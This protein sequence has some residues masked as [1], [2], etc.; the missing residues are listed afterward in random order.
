MIGLGYRNI[1]P[2]M[3]GFNA[4]WKAGR[5]SAQAEIDELASHSEH[6]V[7]LLSTLWGKPSVYNHDLSIEISDA[8]D[9]HE[10]LIAKHKG[11]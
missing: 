1:K 2:E 3:D 6:L 8:I 10:A 9:K 7:T 4:G 11:E 5:A